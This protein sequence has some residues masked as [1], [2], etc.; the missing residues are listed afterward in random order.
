MFVSTRM[1]PHDSRLSV[2]IVDKIPDY[3]EVNI[4]VRM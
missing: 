1:L 2:L 3:N 4:S